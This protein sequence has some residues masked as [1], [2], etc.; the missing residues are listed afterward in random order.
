VS[1]EPVT[2]I[3]QKLRDVQRQDQPQRSETNLPFELLHRSTG[4]NW[5][6]LAS[7]APVTGSS[8][9]TRSP[10]TA[11]AYRTYD[12]YYVRLVA[13]NSCEQGVTGCGANT[14]SEETVRDH[15]GSPNVS[16]TG[17]TDITAG[18]ATLHA[19]IVRKPARYHL[20][21]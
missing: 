2:P 6:S 18:E 9:V 7:K 10:Q 17:V 16:G 5:T 3:A 15:G 1:I 21:L 11:T 19:T 4:T 13:E 14:S 12:P 20:S 8:E